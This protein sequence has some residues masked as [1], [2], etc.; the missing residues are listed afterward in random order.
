MY[1]HGEFNTPMLCV[2]LVNFAVRILEIKTRAGKLYGKRYK[3]LLDK[4]ERKVQFYDD[5]R[6]QT[7]KY[8]STECYDIA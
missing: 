8:I 5:T 4:F 2:G 6:K 3:K 1:S 7:V